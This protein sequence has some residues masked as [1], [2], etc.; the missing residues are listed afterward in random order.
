MQGMHHRVILLCCVFV[1]SCDWTFMAWDSTPQRIR[2]WHVLKGQHSMWDL[3][4]EQGQC[5]GCL[6]QPSI[7]HG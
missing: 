7:D 4:W 6:R 2:P 1:V 3:W 5:Q